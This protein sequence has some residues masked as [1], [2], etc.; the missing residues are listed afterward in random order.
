MKDSCYTLSLFIHLY[1]AVDYY[2]LSELQSQS[3]KF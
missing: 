1:K 2:R 3:L